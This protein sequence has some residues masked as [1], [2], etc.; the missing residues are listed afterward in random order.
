MRLLDKYLFRESLVFFSIS[1]FVFTG[2]LLTLRMLKFAALIVNRGVELS[3]IS[4]VFIS[5]IPTFLEFAIPLSVLLGIMLAVGRLS[6]DSEVI[7]MRASGV[8]IFSLLRP[9]LL[10]AG[11]CALITLFVAVYLSPAGAK[12]LNNTLFNIAKSRSLSGLD[13]GVFNKLGALTL[14]T[15]QI[16]Y[17]SGALTHVLIDDERDN[18][19]AKIITAQRGKILSDTQAQTINI[20]LEDGYIHEVL[21]NKY[22]ITQYDHNSIALRPDELYDEEFYKRD[23]TPR[24]LTLAE[25]KEEVSAQQFQ[26]DNLLPAND[27]PLIQPQETNASLDKL[28]TVLPEASA[29]PLPSAKDLKRKIA[30]LVSESGRR[31][32]MPFACIALALLALPLGVQVPRTQRTWGSGLSTSLGVLVFVV[33]YSFFS[34]GLALA[35]KGTLNPF[36]ALWLPNLVIASLGAFATWK[37]ASEKW[38]SVP[39]AMDMWLRKRWVGAAR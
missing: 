14:Y 5:I 11:G 15:E 16:D 18:Q 38:Q 23:R 12:S 17:Q 19:N 29:T 34:I 24:E 26:L 32:S 28:N 31:F 13:A 10:F 25:L 8:S 9:V 20:E 33:Y 7:V 6:A 35:E 39:Y 2:I 3:Q 22:G 37:V 36:I 21:E 27:T 30:R 4:L 1:L